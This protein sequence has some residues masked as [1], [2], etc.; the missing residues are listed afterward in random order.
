MFSDFL[1]LLRLWPQIDFGSGCGEEIISGFSS[2]RDFRGRKCASFGCVRILQIFESWYSI[3]RYSRFIGFVQQPPA[4][5]SFLNSKKWQAGC[6][7]FN[8]MTRDKCESDVKMSVEGG[9]K[10]EVAH[11]VIQPWNVEGYE[12]AILGNILSMTAR[13]DG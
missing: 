6:T 7:L 3:Y 2:C 10:T 4:R 8:G 12:A 11:V 9:S 13:W 5:S 1:H